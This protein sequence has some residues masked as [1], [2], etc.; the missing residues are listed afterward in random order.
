MLL[1][2]KPSAKAGRFLLRADTKTYSACP[3]AT[4]CAGYDYSSRSLLQ[5]VA[6]DCQSSTSK[7]LTM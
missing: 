4:G 2:N 3:C 1:E 7:A 6:A 5:K